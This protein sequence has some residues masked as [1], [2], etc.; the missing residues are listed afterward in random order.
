M[1]G[2]LLRPFF[3][4][5]GRIPRSTFW[6]AAASLATVFVVLFVFIEAAVGRAATLVLLHRQRSPRVV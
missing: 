6:I 1:T 3:A 2:K 4:F 5:R